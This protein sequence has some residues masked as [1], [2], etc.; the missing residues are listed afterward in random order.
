MTA[1]LTRPELRA[2]VVDGLKARVPALGSRVLP[3][4]AWPLH[5]AQMPAALVHDERIRRTSL[6][7]ALAA[8]TYRTLVSMVVILRAEGASEAEVVAQL[9]DLAAATEAALLTSPEFMALAEEVPDLTSDRE[10]RAEADR[11]I[12]QEAIAFDLQFTEVFDPAGLPDFTEA[13]MTLDAAEPFDATG[14]YPAIGDFPAPAAPP[15]ES[16]PDGRVEAEIRIT[17]PQP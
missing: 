9:D 6:A 8:P 14:A 4:R 5:L 11:V 13:R 15:R 17:Y 1:G 7:R 3:G 12:G 2:A 10:I 16:G